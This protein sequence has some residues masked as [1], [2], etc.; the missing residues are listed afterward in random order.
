MAVKIETEDGTATIE[1]GK[2]VASNGFLKS[3][4][5]SYTLDTLEEE[6]GYHPWPDL[7]IAEMAIAEM[8]GEIIET[9]DQP[10]F[11]EGVVY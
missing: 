5:K 6:V 10:V 9:I 11:E 8:G 2:W 1:N 4:L 3:L 7:G